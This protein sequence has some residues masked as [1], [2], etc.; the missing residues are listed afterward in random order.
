[1]VI[2]NRF[3]MVMIWFIIQLK[4]P[5]QTGVPGKNES[6]NSQSSLHRK[7]SMVAFPSRRV[8]KNYHE[9]QQRWKTARRLSMT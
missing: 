5:Q 7:G 2:S 4:Q 1:M 6:N 3:S 9:P 8:F